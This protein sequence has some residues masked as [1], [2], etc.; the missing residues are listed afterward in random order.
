MSVLESCTHLWHQGCK[1]CNRRGHLVFEQS[2]TKP[3]TAK[4][5]SEAMVDIMMAHEE[6]QRTRE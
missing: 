2:C 5:L 3:K 6:L 4:H 1:L